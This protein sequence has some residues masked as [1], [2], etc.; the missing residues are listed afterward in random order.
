MGLDRWGAPFTQIAASKGATVENR[1]LIED[2]GHTAKLRLHPDPIRINEM[3]DGRPPD[4]RSE[5]TYFKDTPQATFARVR[6]LNMDG[7]P[8]VYEREFIFVKNRFLATRETVTFEESFK[9]RVAPLWN[10]HNIGPQIG[11]H[12]ANTFIH[13][14][15]DLSLIHI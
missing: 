10:T 11:R 2:I 7:L 14:P 1:A 5:V 8:V 4:I 12:W 15:I 3:W 6:V 9:A 13:A